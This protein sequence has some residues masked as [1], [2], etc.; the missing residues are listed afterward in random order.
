MAL[1]DARIAY[2]PDVDKHNGVLVRELSKYLYEPTPSKLCL[3]IYSG[4][5]LQ[6]Y[7]LVQGSLVSNAYAFMIRRYR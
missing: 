2:Q 4:R 7:D 3:L 6:A 5:F 1:A